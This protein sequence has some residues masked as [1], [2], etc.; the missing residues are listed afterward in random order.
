M[1]LKSPHCI[2]RVEQAGQPLHAIR[3]D[4]RWHHLDGDL[5]D[6]YAPGRPF[7]PSDL[8]VLAPVEPSKI[9]AVGLNY[10]DHAREMHKALPDVP[11]IFLKPPSAIIGPGDAIVLP[12]GG[13]A[14]RL[15]GGVGRRDRRP[16]PPGG[17]G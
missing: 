6:E 5:F 2:Y 9:V 15:R 17:G 10:P 12:P 1:T 7:D 3:I 16:N 14:G 4:D 13:W 8:R 11:L